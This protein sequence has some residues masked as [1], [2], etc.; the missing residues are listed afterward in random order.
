MWG[1]LGGGFQWFYFYPTWG[2][3]LIWSNLTIVIFFKWVET[4]NSWVY[5]FFACSN[6]AILWRD[7]R[8]HEKYLEVFFLPSDRTNL[9]RNSFFPK[10]V[11]VLCKYCTHFNTES[12]NLSKEVVA[13]MSQCA[14]IAKEKRCRALWNVMIAPLL[15]YLVWRYAFLWQVHPEEEMKWTCKS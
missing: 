13:P 11:V 7:Q 3:N 15:M 14:E 4:T 9:W 2:N 6:D 12:Q 1:L 8:S 10:R 5:A